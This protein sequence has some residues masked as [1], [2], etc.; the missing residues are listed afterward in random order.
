MA[1]EEPFSNPLPPEKF[2]PLSNSSNNGSRPLRNEDFRALLQTP[3]P[4]D[5]PA[6]NSRFA[7]L[8]PF[9]SEKKTK[10]V[11][12]VKERKKRKYK[13]KKAKEEEQKSKYRDRAKER[14]EE[15][16]PDYDKVPEDLKGVWDLSEGEL[17]KLSI[18]S[19]KYLGGDMKHTHLV[20]GLDFALLA[21]MRSEI[22]EKERQEKEEIAKQTKAKNVHSH[23]QIIQ[24]DG[25]VKTVE[26][27]TEFKTHIGKAVFHYLFEKQ[28]LSQ[29]DDFLPGRTSYVY[30]LDQEYDQELP[31]TVKRSKED[32]PETKELV[33]ARTHPEILTKIQKIMVYYKQGAKAYKKMKRK[34]K[35]KRKRE[36]E[37]LKE[38]EEIKQKQMAQVSIFDD[39]KDREYKPEPISRKK[40]KTDA[41]AE[42]DGT[43]FHETSENQISTMD[44]QTTSKDREDV[45]E[46]S[47][48]ISNQ[49]P[50]I[51]PHNQYP[52]WPPRTVAPQS[53]PRLPQRPP[54]KQQLKQL[55]DLA[56]HTQPP[57]EPAQ[58]QGANDQVQEGIHSI[59][60][61]DQN[62]QNRKETDKRERDAS[63][64]SDSYT[65]CYPGTYEGTTY[66][67]CDSDEDEDLTKM[68]SKQRLR[69]WDFESDEAWQ[70][71]EQRREALPKAA[72]QFG[73]KMADGRRTRKK[74]KKGKIKRQLKQINELV[75]EMDPAKKG[76]LHAALNESKMDLTAQFKD[77]GLFK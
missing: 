38:E 48:E 72:F 52:E 68:D 8:D 34:E 73:V 14:R 65:E 15:V 22:A 10:Q 21:K 3:R 49:K 70:D 16:N 51:G 55:V 40:Q 28:W 57:P 32:C 23:K 5:A 46:P 19:S 60:R 56:T 69:R 11:D 62:L 29:I 66:A 41:A 71:Y 17:S 59:W 67:A 77:K 47:S 63:F 64:V 58:P 44:T 45:V 30:E 74:Q 18:E 43:Y 1:A 76:K 33:L 7:H 26:A 61:R 6:T 39:V 2:N 37:K 35:A 36:E 20:K 75:E 50:A 42:K 53:G 4:G 13:K 12:E 54:S 27:Q 24:Q 31:T 25:F 9:R